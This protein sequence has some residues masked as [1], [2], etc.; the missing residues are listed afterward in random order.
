[1]AAKRL[2][3]ALIDRLISQEVFQQRSEALLLEEARLKERQIQIDSQR[4]DP[5][6][7]RRFL[8]LVKNLA[9]TYL[10]AAP[11]QKQQIARIATS[12][13]TVVGKSIYMEPSK[14]LQDVGAAVAALNGAPSPRAARTEI[15]NFHEIM[16][17][18]DPQR[19]LQCSAS[20]QDLQSG[21]VA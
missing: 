16:N 10:I 18:E 21:W 12:N 5:E 17:R 15:S 14:W 19:L 4:A 6:Q 7:T 8:E 20:P 3:D 9:F 1:M 13:R 11:A 2:S